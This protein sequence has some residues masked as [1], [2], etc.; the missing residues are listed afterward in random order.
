MF[1]TRHSLLICKLDDITMTLT[2]TDVREIDCENN[3][4]KTEVITIRSTVGPARDIW[5]PRAQK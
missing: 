2:K 5:V 3:I 4:I 1:K